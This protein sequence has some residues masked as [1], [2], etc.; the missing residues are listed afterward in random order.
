[1]LRF[2]LLVAI[3][4]TFTPVALADGL[5]VLGID[6]GSTGVTVPGGPDRYV[7]VNQ[8]GTTL[9]ERIARNGGRILGIGRV[10]GT[11]TIPAVAY[12]SSA[13]G[14]SADRTTL[15]LIEPRHA[16]PRAVTRFALLDT[17]TLELRHVITLRG[18]FSFDAV[19]P[20]GQTMFLIDYTSPSDPTR[21]DVRAYDLRADRLLRN[22]IRDPAERSDAMRG[23]PITRAMSS[24]GRWAYTLYDGAGAT[25]FVHALDTATLR[26]HCIDLSMLAGRRDLW[27]LRFTPGP[28]DTLLIAKAGTAL[29]SVDLVGFSARPPAA[30]AAPVLRPW[31]LAGAVLTAL[32][33][34]G[35]AASVARRRVRGRTAPFAGGAR[36]VAE[37][38]SP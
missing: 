30:L 15:V 17:H 11:F 7:T 33:L 38:R 14:L 9:V 27:S 36:H 28:N 2:V 3:A 37:N 29:A 4:C 25:P 20:H 10:G 23:A 31:L 12:D 6:V 5:P 18:D 24:N 22:A 16:F 8:G 13:S 35:I 21:Y 19:S 32:L 26:A 1:M 34:L